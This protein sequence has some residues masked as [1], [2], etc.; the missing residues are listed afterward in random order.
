MKHAFFQFYDYRTREIYILRSAQWVVYSDGFKDGASR[1][2]IHPTHISTGSENGI[3]HERTS[4]FIYIFLLLL[5]YFLFFPPPTQVVCDFFLQ[6]YKEWVSESESKHTQYVYVQLTD[7]SLSYTLR[8]IFLYSLQHTHSCALALLSLILYLFWCT[9]YC[10]IDK[11]SFLPSFLLLELSCVYKFHHKRKK[12]ERK[13][14]FLSTLSAKE[15]AACI[16]RSCKGFFFGE[17][18]F[19]SLITCTRFRLLA[20][21]VTYSSEIV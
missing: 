18:L 1:E 17:S 13:R 9:Q 6:C 5:Y 14:M 21:R 8:S 11:H 3:K 20:D 16:C 12:R 15:G 10:F 4:E 7:F 19:K 2:W